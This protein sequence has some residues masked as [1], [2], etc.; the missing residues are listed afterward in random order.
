MA[1]ALIAGEWAAYLRSSLSESRC[2]LPRWNLSSWTPFSRYGQSNR[3]STIKAFQHVKPLVDC[4]LGV[5]SSIVIP[6]LVGAVV[7]DYLQIRCTLAGT[8]IGVAPMRR[9]RLRFKDRNADDYYVAFTYNTEIR[10][11]P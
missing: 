3:G 4:V 9:Q 10:F 7:N 5:F 11:L 8:L 6:R 2:F 1:Q